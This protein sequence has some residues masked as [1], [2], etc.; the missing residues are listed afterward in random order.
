MGGGGESGL[1]FFKKAFQENIQPFWKLESFFWGGGS[2]GKK[3]L[4]LYSCM[5]LRYYYLKTNRLFK[6][7]SYLFVNNTDIHVLVLHVHVLQ[8]IIPVGFVPHHELSC[9]KYCLLY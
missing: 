7:Y 1:N 5:L 9:V 8:H 2:L 6:S 4:H 3:N